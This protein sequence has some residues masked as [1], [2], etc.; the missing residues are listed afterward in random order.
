MLFIHLPYIDTQTNTMGDIE[1]HNSAYGFDIQSMDKIERTTTHLK[2][3]L[4]LGVH[5][6][7]RV[8]QLLQIDI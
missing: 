7:H 4:K 3:T 8:N 2:F 1:I 5:F 6:E